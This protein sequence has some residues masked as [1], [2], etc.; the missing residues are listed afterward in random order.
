MRDL[1]R[2][3]KLLEAVGDAHGD[4]LTLRVLDVCSEESVRQC[5]GGLEDRRVD[6]LSG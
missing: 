1:K 5:V 6:V 3:E 4:T 2:K